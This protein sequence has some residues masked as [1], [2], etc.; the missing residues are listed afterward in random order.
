MSIDSDDHMDGLF[1]GFNNTKMCR[2]WIV[3]VSQ[4]MFDYYAIRTHSH[5]VRAGNEILLSKGAGLRA[6]LSVV[7]CSYSEETGAREIHSTYRYIDKYRHVTEFE[8]SIAPSVPLIA[9]SDIPKLLS[10]INGDCSLSLN[11]IE[12]LIL[13]MEYGIYLCTIATSLNGLAALKFMGYKSF[14]VAHAKL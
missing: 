10:K 2:S 4:Q 14:L 11:A 13:S 5:S 7:S 8:K 6:C 3:R 12:N 9:L 1:A